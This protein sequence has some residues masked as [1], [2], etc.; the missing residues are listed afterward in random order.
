MSKGARK[1][2]GERRRQ[3]RDALVRRSQK[4][5]DKRTILLVGEGEETERNYFDAIKREDIVAKRF[6]VTVKKRHGVSPERVVEEAI[7]YKEQ[8]ES[9]GED[10]DEVWCVLDVEGSEKRDSLEAAVR[11]AEENGITL[12][13]SNPCFEVWLLSHFER[14]SRAYNNCDVVIVRLNRKWRTLCRQDYRK[15]DD[16]IYQRV[17]GLTEEAIENA[18]LVRE[19]DHRDIENTAD[20][21]SSTEVYRLVGKLMG[22]LEA[23]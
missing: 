7:G 9:R 11:L 19:V 6:A 17:S 4:R 22:G 13:L 12:Y 21:N 20:C 2:G 10:F 23:S 15:N 8:A 3:Q 16:R 18:R 14:R 1:T 5:R